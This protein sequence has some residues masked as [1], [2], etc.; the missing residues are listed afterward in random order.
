ME[1]VG[2]PSADDVGFYNNYANALRHAGRGPAAEAIL[3]EIVASDP[4]AWQPWHNL[5]QT[6][7]DLQRFDDAASAMERAIS[8]EPDF[9]PN[10]AVLG[11]ILFHLGD[12]EAALAELQ[13]CVDLCWTTDPGMWSTIGAVSTL[14]RAAR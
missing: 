2:S 7:R 3:R 8:L 13:T 4:E 10:H 12:P 1:R 9:G 11:E 6:L 5:G 14:A